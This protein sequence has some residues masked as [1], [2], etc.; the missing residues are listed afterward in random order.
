MIDWKRKLLAFLHD[1]PHKPVGIRDHEQQRDSFLNRFDLASADMQ[2][3]ER[4]ADWQAAAADRLIFPDHAKSGLR[5]DWK[6]S[7]LE[8][9]HPL[10]GG[11]L[12]AGAFPPTAA[13]LED[14]LTRALE[15]AAMRD[16]Q[17]WKTKFIAGWRLWPELSAREKNAHF[18]YLVADTRI[19]DH[20]LWHHNALAAAFTGCDGHPA[21][22]LFQIGPVQDFIAQ[23]RKTQD[24]WSGSYLL[25]FLIAQAMLAIAEEI[26]PDAIVFPQLRGLPLADF[27]WW[28]KAHFGDVKLRASHANELLTPNLPNRFLALVP[29][30]R[31]ADLARVAEKA[32]RDT[33][34]DI[35][36]SV[37]SFLETQIN[38]H[39]SGWDRHWETQVNR[40]PVVDWVVHAWSDTPTALK[41]AAEDTPP[42]HGGWSQHPLR[43]AQRW[44]EEFIPSEEREAYGPTSNA[45]F[46]WALHYA[47]TDWKFAAAKNARSFAQWQA[48]GSLDADGVPKDHLDGK[49]EV[50]GG[51][52]HEK[53]WKLLREHPLLGER[54]KDH[55]YAERHFIGSQLYGALSVIKRLWVRAF[56][57]TRKDTPA[58]FFDFDVGEE[59]RER[60]KSVI[61][62]A[63]GR[64]EPW[65]WDEGDED[66]ERLKP[67]ESYYAVLAMDGDDLGHW[68]SG[69]KAAPLINSLAQEARDYFRN[70]WNQDATGVP[71]DQVKR[72]LSPGYH[73]ALSEAL[74]NFSLYC[75]GPI[76]RA[77][78]G[79]LIYTGGDDVL[80]MLPARTALDCAQALQLAFR[81]VNPESPDSSASAEVKKVLQDLFNYERH[82]DGFLTLRKTERADVGR[83]THLKPNWPLMVMGP[84]ATASVGIAIG[85]VRSPMQDTIQAAREAESTAKKAELKLPDGTVRKKGAFCLN[86][87]K[88]SGEAV[89]FAAKWSSGVGSVWGE[90]ETKVHDLSGRFT[91][92]YASLVKALV[93]TGGGP[94][95]A[96]YAPTWDETLK[97][98]VGAELRHVLRQQ[99]G[100]KAD[101]ALELARHWCGILLPALSPRDFLHFWLTWAFVNRLA[102]P[103]T[104]GDDQ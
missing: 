87:L 63:S 30:P 62:I 20:T 93:V 97:E 38:G 14:E 72:P 61:E 53:F 68:V 96:A 46:A 22:L 101:K 70:Y 5:V 88:R 92:R 84:Q 77:F 50:L 33:W 18:A 51:P 35:A 91:Y 19:P 9:R 43:L 3:F 49:N 59:L 102:K 34:Q 44:A 12:K 52:D 4:S 27:H 25:S 80:A 74:S 82:V 71:A 31:A 1:P 37:K 65:S 78:G 11:Q 57:S 60:F 48:V 29:G 26:G 94:E 39:C 73:A 2:E 89:G 66:L 10:G 83:A 103:Q 23:A 85:H 13:Q 69:E 81:G 32:V 8:F 64:K 104:N 75:A 17:D 45:G 24:L 79:Q 7:W 6:A 58:G 36:K 56:L 76:V 40:F 54:T 90:L 86:V 67:K 55:P 47:V 15:A 95:G 21:F 28:K 100:Y 42:L 99:G 16:S 41:L 98:A